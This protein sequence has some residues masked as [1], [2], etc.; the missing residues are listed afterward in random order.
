[1]HS[2][3]GAGLRR[4]HFI[5]G[6]KAVVPLRVWMCIKSRRGDLGSEP[7]TDKSL[8]FFFLFVLFLV[9]GPISTAAIKAY[10]TLTPQWN[11]VI[12]LQRRSTPGVR[13]LC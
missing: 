5:T 13:D 9:V 12:H 1:M 6:G 10:C 2:Y 4:G 11:S 7:P 3:S 8:P